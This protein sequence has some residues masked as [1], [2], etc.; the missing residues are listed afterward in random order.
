MSTLTTPKSLNSSDSVSAEKI[1]TVFSTDIARQKNN[2][3]DESVQ[4]IVQS[5][6]VGN[7]KKIFGE[8]CVGTL[9]Q[10]VDVAKDDLEI[11]ASITIREMV[12][13]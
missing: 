6:R 12:V 7:S 1:E 13:F 8:N 9:A 2:F 5:F 10:I 4:T 3:T 11:S